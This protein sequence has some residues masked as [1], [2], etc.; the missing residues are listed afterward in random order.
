MPA[1]AAGVGLNTPSAAGTGR[2][3]FAL[4]LAALT[5]AMLA[6][7]STAPAPPAAQSATGSRLASLPL[8][9]VENR[10]QVDPSVRY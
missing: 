2:A 7:W 8:S 10:G 9:F 6:P 3:L 5:A 4:L 1:A